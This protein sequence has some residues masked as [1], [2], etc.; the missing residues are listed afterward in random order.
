MTRNRMFAAFTVAVVAIA[1]QGLGRAASPCDDGH[2]ADGNDCD[3]R[4]RSTHLSAMSVYSHGEFIYSDYVHDD[5]GANVDGLRSGDA[6]PG[7]PVTGMEYPNLRDPAS[8]RNGSTGDNLVG[9]I[10]WTGDFGYP[11][12]DPSVDPFTYN[13]VADLIEFRTAVDDHGLHYLVRLGALIDADDAIVSIGI[14]TDRDATTG[15]A[16]F[17]LGSNLQEQLGFEYVLTLWGTGGALQGPGDPLAPPTPVRV[18]A[19]TAENFIEADVALHPHL[20]TWRTYV[21][22]GLYDAEAGGWAPASLTTTRSAAPGDIMRAP[23]IFDLAFV[24]NEPNTW[25]RE[26]F[27][28]DDLAKHDIA[29]DHADIDM[30]RLARDEDEDGPRPRPTGLINFQYDALPLGPGEGQEWNSGGL[31]SINYI[32]RGAVQPGMVFLPSNY[33]S[34]PHP[35]RFMYFYHCLNCN[36]NIWPLGVE[37]AATPGQQHI[38]DG[39]VGT[40]RIQA[41]ADEYDMIVAG[42]LQRGEGGPSDYGSLVGERD[43]RDVYDFVNSHYSLDHSR[44]VFSGMSMG[45]STTNSQMSLHA[46]EIAAAV[47]HSAASTPARLAN[48]RNLFYMQITGDTGLDGTAASSGRNAA[49]A[50]TNAGFEHMYLEYIGRAHDFNLVYESW[51]IIKSLIRDR[52][53]DPNPARVTYQLDRS[54]ESATLGLSHDHAYWARDLVLTDGAANGTLD[55]TALPLAYKLPTMQ[56]HIQGT[57]INP[58]SGNQA[59]VSWLMNDVDLTGHGLADFEP[60][61]QPGPDVTVTSNGVTP[62]AGAGTNA[63][64]LAT[65][66][67][68]SLTLVM[69]R[70]AIDTHDALHG[71]LTAGTALTLRLAGDFDGVT[72]VLLDGQPVA[73]DGTSHGLTIAIP[74]GTH[75]LEI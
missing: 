17:G 69:S 70:M 45:G 44:E 66:N 51:P 31:G 62:P 36:Q 33:Y 71:A 2:V 3:W 5:S 65:N 57:F 42:S 16:S 39:T 21:A 56:S 37:D 11:P 61:W 64:S 10:R 59:Y 38:H 74:A 20:G 72:S 41:I 52:R 54:T 7:N 48:I 47:S 55:A 15:A 34:D 14:D 8:P 32:Y 22:T 60:G 40:Q 24:P 18:A 23:R 6:D 25:W 13:D 12:A 28:A 49:T 75:T 29:Q 30:R 53:L 67:L 9:R 43:L 27:Q 46:D 19:N 68:A 26:T 35:R 58:E 63:F 50:L 4:G 73:V 1:S